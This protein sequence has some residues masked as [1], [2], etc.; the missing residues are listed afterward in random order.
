LVVS[1]FDFHASWF[2]SASSVQATAATVLPDYIVS[3]VSAAT[4][5][6]V[7]GVV[8]QAVEKLMT[9]VGASGMESTFVE[10]MKGVLR[11]EW[12]V[13]CLDLVIRL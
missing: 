4:D 13:Q 6:A 3:A 1:L 8:D 9:R 11:R 10:W 7:V 2:E 12:R 5:N